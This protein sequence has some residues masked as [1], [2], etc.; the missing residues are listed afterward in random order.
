MPLNLQVVTAERILINEDVDSLVAPGSDGELGI[1]PRHAPL[2]S[3]LKPGE[4]RYRRGGE[5]NFLAIGGGFIE[6]LNNKVIVLADSAERSEEIDLE[7]AES[8][9]R[10]AEQTLANRGQLSV[11]QLAAAE[12][13]LRRAMVRLDIGTRRRG[14]RT[15]IPGR[16]F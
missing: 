9:R 4:L 14:S 3:G 12:A 7:R 13:A 1:L 2:L 8:A 6:V 15:G 10:T 5:E 16:D 11:E